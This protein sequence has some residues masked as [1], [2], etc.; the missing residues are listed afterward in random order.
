MSKITIMADSVELKVIQPIYKSVF[1]KEN[2][3]T[4][5]QVRFIKEMRVRKW[6]QKEAIISVEEY[7]N[8]KNK[9]VKNRC[10]V[11]DKYTGKSYLVDHPVMDVM[12]AKNSPQS[13]IGFLKHT[14]QPNG[15]TIP[16]KRSSV[17]LN[18]RG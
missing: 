13:P 8:A 16:R 17:R 7:L 6:I 1:V 11:Q 9:I 10:V 15:T 5:E 3:E 12:Q 18:G 2:G 14:N 4:V